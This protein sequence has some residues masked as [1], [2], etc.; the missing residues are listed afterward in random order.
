LLKL[1]SGGAFAEIWLT[2][3]W[4]IIRSMSAVDG[5][6]CAVT[7]ADMEIRSVKMAEVRVVMIDLSA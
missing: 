4:A 5:A 1:G 7:D 2:C 6:C 3:T